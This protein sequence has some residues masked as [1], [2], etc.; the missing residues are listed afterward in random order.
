MIKSYISSEYHG[1]YNKCYDKKDTCVIAP[2]M[3][4]ETK[5]NNPLEVYMVLSCV[6]YSV[7][8]KYFCID[9]ICCNYKTLSVIYYYKIL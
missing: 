5:T 2:I 1:M 6:L 4:Y 9:Y 8:E 7:I 3:F